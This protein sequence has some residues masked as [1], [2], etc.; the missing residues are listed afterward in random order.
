MHS[1]PRPIPHWLP[2]ILAFAASLAVYAVTL[3]GSYFYD[4]T[5]LKED[6]RFTHREYWPQFWTREY[7]PNAIDSLYRP[8]T[9]MTFAVEFYVHGDRPWVFHLVNLLLHAGAAAAAA[10]LARRL[11][12][13][14]VACAAGVLFAI[15]PIHVEAVAGLV[16]RAELLCT[17]ATLVGLI[18]FLKPMTALRGLSILTCMVVAML[19]KEQGILFPLMLL[20]ITPHRTQMLNM[21]LTSDNVKRER[22]VMGILS[23]LI[24]ILAAAYLIF[25]E[26]HF[27]FAWDR[28]HLDWAVNPLVRSVGLDKIFMPVTLLGRYTALLLAPAKLSIDYGARVI[29]W[30]V[31]WR[32]PYVYLGFSSLAAWSAFTV[33]ASRGRRWAMVFCLT[34]LAISYGI[35]SNAIVLIGTNFGERLMYLPSAFILI[36]IAA[37]LDRA[38]KPR[39]F[40]AI[41][42]ILAALGA[43]RAF[44]YARLCNDPPALYLSDLR[45]QPDSMSLHGLVVNW[46]M[47]NGNYREAR[48]VGGDC[49]NRLP[50]CWQSYMMCVEPDIKLHDFADAA[51]VLAHVDRQCPSIMIASIRSRLQ[52]ARDAYQLEI[53]VRGQKSKV[54]NAGF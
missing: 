19:S 29:G 18:L 53:E 8:L 36:V 16:G 21:H 38:L 23:A 27:G 9:C 44:T 48:A 10:E 22:G 12:N 30:T 43:V 35:V 14:R 47:S 33:W 15:H 40:A 4:D 24:C 49:L 45:D 39:A 13:A 50:D 3:N 1:A 6:R 37:L 41:V 51:R 5:I 7:M 28:G 17:L 34:A 11:T 31:N 20:A 46:Y 26:Q 32:Q 2:A 54:K 52:S 42:V 25:R